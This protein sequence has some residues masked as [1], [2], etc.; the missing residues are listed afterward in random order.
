MKI[1]AKSLL[2][3]ATMNLL[4]C[5]SD[6]ELESQKKKVQEL[7][8]QLKNVQQLVEDYKKELD[9]KAKTELDAT[10]IAIVDYDVL[11]EKYVGYKVAIQKLER[12]YNSLKD[13]LDKEAADFQRRYE[14]AEKSAQFLKPEQQQAEAAKLQQEYLALQKKQYEY[15]GEYVQ[16]E[17][18]MTKDVMDKVNAHLKEY[19][20]TNGYQ[21]VLFTTVENSL[22]YAKD[23]INITDA[24]L[25]NLNEAYENGFK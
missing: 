17:Q 15:E 10:G 7:N 2:L 11:R 13:K 22:F 9:E 12:K 18:K 5:G 8:S 23:D 25:A 14:S 6:P 19:A 3:A 24:Y 21:M 16:E 1:L 4:S 20:E